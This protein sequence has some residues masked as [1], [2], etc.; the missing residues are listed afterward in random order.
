MILNAKELP[1]CRSISF[2]SDFSPACVHAIRKFRLK[3]TP[4]M[5]H[6]S[7]VFRRVYVFFFVKFIHSQMRTEKNE[8]KLKRP[9]NITN[10]M[11]IFK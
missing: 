1:K 4:Q 3:C 6:R 2:N 10:I 11:A 7:Y 8:E 5:H 9:N